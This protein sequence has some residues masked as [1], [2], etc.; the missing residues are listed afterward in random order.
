MNEQGKLVTEKEAKEQLI[1]W[2][3]QYHSVFV[4]EINEIQFVWRELSRAEFR[5]S[6]DYFDDDYDRAEYIC[7]LCVLDPMVDYDED[8]YAG[9]PET[10]AQQI[11]EESGFTPDNTK[12]KSLM[13]EYEAD[14]QRF[15]NQVSCVIAEVFPQIPLDE[16]EH[17]NVEKTLWYFSRA[18]WILK[19]LR[20]VELKE[21]DDPLKQPMNPPKG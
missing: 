21:D 17:W 4:T 16:I 15:E 19:T 18:N 12:I 11:M 9:I 8:I 1:K 14:M 6:V 20:G 7:K 2:K 10:L 5:K 3:D 13:R